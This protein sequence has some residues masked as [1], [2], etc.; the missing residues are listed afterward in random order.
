M[1]I[2]LAFVILTSENFLINI[3]AFQEGILIKKLSA[4]YRGIVNFK[5]EESITLQANGLYFY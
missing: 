4:T 2:K 1:R 5:V 3:F